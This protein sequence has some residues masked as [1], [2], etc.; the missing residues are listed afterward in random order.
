MGETGRVICGREEIVDNIKKTQGGGNVSICYTADVPSEYVGFLTVRLARSGFIVTERK[1]D[2]R[3]KKDV[4]DYL[5]PIDAV[6]MIIGAGDGLFADVVAA[7][8]RAKKI[9]AVFIPTGYYSEGRETAAFFCGGGFEYYRLSPFEAVFA[10]GALLADAPPKV[11][12]GAIGVYLA[13]VLGFFDG[14]LGNL[15]LNGKFDES[16]VDAALKNYERALSD[17]TALVCPQSYGRALMSAALYN[18]INPS[19]G[20]GEAA[21]ITAYA[22]VKLYKRFLENDGFDLSIPK[23][24]GGFFDG[25]AKKYDADIVG[26]LKNLQP[27]SVGEYLKRAYVIDEYRG[28]L[29]SLINKID[30]LLPRLLKSF[31]RMYRDAG[32]FLKDAVEGRDIIGALTAA[33]SLGGDF[34]LSR[35]IDETGAFDLW[36]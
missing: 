14:T 16:G 18:R 30:A 12:A 27:P 24:Y 35:H 9:K 11:R 20:I 36:A 34:S 3:F 4:I 21:F 26:V 6:R 15:I 22:Q 33:A 17:P 13:D 5:A 2:G 23:D 19:L 8:A 7:A 25:L 29:L 31:R 28:E 1:F 32:F 10:D